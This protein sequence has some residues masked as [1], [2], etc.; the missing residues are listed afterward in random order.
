MQSEPSITLST[1]IAILS[2]VFTLW[3]LITGWFIVRCNKLRDLIDKKADKED[4]SKLLDS[5]DKTLDK[6]EARVDELFISILNSKK[7][8]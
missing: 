8:D 4:M 6:V 7:G 3:G 5:C 1:M 2:L